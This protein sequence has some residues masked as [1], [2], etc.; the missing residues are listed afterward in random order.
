MDFSLV[1]LL[2]QKLGPL[3][4]VFTSIYF[5]ELESIS[6]RIKTKCEI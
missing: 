4:F 3:K 1:G 5:D 6:I 2:T